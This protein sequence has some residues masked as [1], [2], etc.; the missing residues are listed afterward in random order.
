MKTLTHPAI[1][2]VL[3]L[4][5]ACKSEAP[6]PK[7]IGEA[8]VGPAT[9]PMRA[10]L[11]TR[12]ETVADL[13]HGE[14]LEILL[15][16]RRFLKVRNMGGVEGWV[17]GR[18]LLTAKEL[19]NLKQ[20][21]EIA[22]QIPSQGKASVYDPLN[23]HTEPNR[24]SPSPFQIPAGGTVEIVGHTVAVRASFEPRVLA[25]LNPPRPPVARKP[26][27]KKGTKGEPEVEPPPMPPAPKLPP[28]WV[29]L[30]KSVRANLAPA[31]EPSKAEA[32]K[33]VEA[34]QIKADDWYLV[35]TPDKKAGWVLARMMVIGI[36]DE[37]ATYAEGK[38]ITAYFEL[39]QVKDVVKDEE[40]V[41][42]HWLWT[43]QSQGLRPFQFDGLR[44]FIWNNRRHRYETAYRER[45]IKGYY[46][47]LR[48]T[49]EVMEGRQ[50]LQLPAFTVFSE[51]EAGRFWKRS[52]VFQVNR[53][54]MIGA[55]QVD[56]PGDGMNPQSIL[57]LVSQQSSVAT[58]AETSIVDKV[59]S[60]L[61]R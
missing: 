25:E 46:P 49:A 18:N 44:V 27:K 45:D 5:V 24:S 16:R 55:Q 11:N 4:L 21:I 1:A 30:S 36:P 35:R 17:D 20:T 40:V 57:K 26:K 59:K 31:P 54:R 3:C 8:Y 42:H 33:K 2:V 32:R 19:E 53:V 43:T 52:Y 34:P 6:K 12:A 7:A 60:I 56:K 28:N 29:A 47:V 50:K 14:K 13:K 37:V 58:P 41:K 10:E 22:S 15:Q 39:G 51:D 38:R 48:H 23:M 9:L 61:K